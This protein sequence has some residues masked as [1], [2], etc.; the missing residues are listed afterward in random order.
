MYV[1]RLIAIA[2]LCA[3]S[4]PAFAAKPLREAPVSKLPQWHDFSIRQQ[5]ALETLQICEQNEEACRSADVAR[6]AKLIDDLKT[7]SRLRQIITVNRWFN[8]LPYKHDE[9]AYDKL[10]YWADTAALLEKRGDC[11]DY[12]LAKYYTLRQLGFRPEE[13]KVTVVYDSE[14]Y[15]NHA[16]LMVYVNGTR[17]MLDIN[18]DNTDPSPMISRYK[19]LYTFNE[20]KAWFY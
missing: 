19:T 1:F 3:A 15:L 16:V 18:G 14:E 12:A 5:D 20:N 17:Y 10:D 6:W 11:E 7:Q 8:R 13:L 9:Y 2:A 4:L